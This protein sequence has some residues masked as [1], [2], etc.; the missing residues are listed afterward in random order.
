MATRHAPGHGGFRAGV[1]L[2]ALALAGISGASLRPD[3]AAAA[4]RASGAPLAA[5]SATSPT[6][7]PSRAFPLGSLVQSQPLAT[8]AGGLLGA[9]SLIYLLVLWNRP[10]WLLRLPDEGVQIPWPWDPSK[11]LPLGPGLI[12]SLKYRPRVLDAWVQEHLVLI[13]PRFSAITTVE[14]RRHHLSLPVMVG[15]KIESELTPQRLR[16]IDG[17]DALVLISGEG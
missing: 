7:Q 3:P 14:Q 12:R 11:K 16:Q 10:R 13:K 2:G 5:K 4:S 1:L 17:V 8:A 15:H 6:P 9:L